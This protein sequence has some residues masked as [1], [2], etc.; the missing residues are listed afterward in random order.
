MNNGK[1]FS[2]YEWFSVLTERDVPEK[3]TG[4][5][6]Q[7]DVYTMVLAAMKK[8]PG[9]AQQIL[10]LYTGDPEYKILLLTGIYGLPDISLKALNRPPET[11]LS[12]IN[13][14][15]LTGNFREAPAAP[16]KKRS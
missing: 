16:P 13:K 6:A 9:V 12:G 15:Y 1:T 10:D 4:T 8:D 3:I 5:E 7:Q 11:K 2:G 14:K